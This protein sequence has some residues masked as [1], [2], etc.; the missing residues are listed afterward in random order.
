AL[1][2]FPIGAMHTLVRAW[3]TLSGPAPHTGRGAPSLGRAH[4]ASVHPGYS[5]LAWS[6]KNSRWPVFPY[7]GPESDPWRTGVPPLVVPS[8]RGPT[9]K[10]PQASFRTILGDNGKVYKGNSGTTRS[11][12]T[13]YIVTYLLVRLVSIR[14]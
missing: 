11:M 10:V 3:R 14:P 6:R 8:H 2:R 4:T 7:P 12:E 5:L 13:V 1:A 9:R